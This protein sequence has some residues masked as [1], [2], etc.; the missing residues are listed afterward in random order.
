MKVVAIVQARMGSTRLPNKVMKLIGGVPMI[1]LLL[2]RLARATQVDE[3]T[4][5]TSDDPRSADLVLVVQDLTDRRESQRGLSV[6]HLVSQ[7]IAESKS[8]PETLKTVLA[9]V[10]RALGCRACAE[11]CVG[12]DENGAV[13]VKYSPLG[14]RAGAAVIRLGTGIARYHSFLV[15]GRH[16]N[17]RL[18]KKI[19]QPSYYPK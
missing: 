9:E 15:R 4:L 19:G 3:I 10:G 12:V 8:P 17:S 18:R 11:R 6:Q 2:A 13:V 5:A 7:I 16:A 1:E 14:I